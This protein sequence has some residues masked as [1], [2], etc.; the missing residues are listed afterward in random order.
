MDEIE[1]SVVEASNRNIV[2]RW[3]DPKTGK[4]KQKSAGTRVRRE[5]ERAAERLKKQLNDAGGVVPTRM[6]W[7]DFCEKYELQKLPS[8]SRNSRDIWN[9]AKNSFDDWDEVQTEVPKVKKLLDVNADRIARW[10]AWLRQRGRSADTIACYTRTLLA[11]LR[12]AKASE[13]LTS[14]PVVSV[15]KKTKRKRRKVRGRAITD[16]E[17]PK[18]LA[19]VERVMPAAE[20]AEWKRLLRGLWFSGLRIGEAVALSWDADA[21][22]RVDFSG[23]RPKLRISEEAHKAG[24]EVTL[25]L[26]PDFAEFLNETPKGQR[27]GRVFPIATEYFRA[28]KG[29]AA[30]GAASGIVVDRKAEK[31]ASAHDL[32]RSFGT[33]WAQRVKKP[34]VLQKLMRHKSIETTLSYYVDLDA[35]DLGDELD[36]WSDTFSDTPSDSSSQD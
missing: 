2:L 31:F 4:M 21:D 24:D 35:D 15:E 14:V 3:I 33:R 30:I 32:R 13:M 28:Q 18:M 34:L 29:V 7:D 19:A 22:L 16:A 26:T 6:S 20:V 23:R 17:F 1:V 27:R 5:A 12:W 36:R 10:H 11:A 8:L 25:P 9:S